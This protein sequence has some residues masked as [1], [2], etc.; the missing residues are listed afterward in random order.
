MMKHATEHPSAVVLQGKVYMGGGWSGESDKK[1]T[2][3]AVYDPKSDEWDHSLPLYK[4]EWFGMAAIHGKLVLAGGRDPRNGKESK[5]IGVWD[6]RR[7][8]WTAPYSQL[9]S[10]RYLPTVIGYR[11]W[12][13][14]A[15][16]GN[17]A[18]SVVN[19]YDLVE[20]LDTATNEWFTASP[21]PLGCIQMSHALLNDT[22]YLLG[23]WRDNAPIKEVFAIPLHSLI[24]DALCSTSRSGSDPPQSSPW[25]TLATT[26][27][28]YSTALAFQG[29]LLAIGGKRARE[30]GGQAESCIY[31]FERSMARWISVGELAFPRYW[32]ASVAL[33]SGFEFLILGGRNSRQG[34]R[35]RFGSVTLGTV[36][37]TN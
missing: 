3:V 21:L 10:A 36:A 24:V 18:G 17:S 6:P 9:R 8:K 16:G 7:H 20:V 28:G 27:L 23:G 29:A 2:A 14:V 11:K 35:S 37:N 13:I 22:L 12:L 15:G 33:P 32:C 31:R 25:R 5:D 26:P 4:T 1:N 34:S 30:E 19:A